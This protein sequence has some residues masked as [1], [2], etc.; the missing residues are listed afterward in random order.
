MLGYVRFSFFIFVS[1][2]IFGCAIL[3]ETKTKRYQNMDNYKYAFITQTQNVTAGAGSG[4]V[5]YG[6]GGGFSSSVSK[7]VNPSDVIAGILMKKGYIILDNM[8]KKDGLF[9]VRY[10]QGDKRNVLG[11]IGGYTLGVTI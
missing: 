2:A 9:I 3:K 10:G 7:S 4:Y 8:E 5:G 11:G 6:T 1:F